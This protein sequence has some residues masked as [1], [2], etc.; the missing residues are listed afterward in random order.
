MIQ[1]IER[2]AFIKQAAQTG[3]VFGIT[4]LTKE[5]LSAAPKPLFQISL[6]QWSLHK[7]LFAKQLDNLD[8]AKTA[9]Q[10]YGINAVEYVNQFFKD[11]AQDKT[12]LGEMLKRT[13][14]LGVEN[15]LIMCDGEGNLGD[16]DAAK[17]QQAVENHYKWVE[18]A[19]FLGCTIIRVNAA[20]RGSYEEQQKLA[21]DGL[22]KLTEFGAQHKI[23]V[24][25]ENHGGLSSNGQWL[26]GVM[27]LVK[28]KNCGTLPDFGNFRL[29][30]TEE[31]DRYKGVA[32]MMPYAKAVSAKTHDFDAE[33]NETH[34]DYRRMV[35][36]V[37]DA[38]YHSFFGIEYEGDKL[39]EPDG[40]RASKKLLER[41]HQELAPK[42]K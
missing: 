38:G 8:F 37:L 25:V 5:T 33:G 24:I 20:S 12:Y 14:D 10:D 11:K 39:S 21:A 9:K 2:R 1:V 4:A 17:R 32:E 35:K 27:K 42:A 36:L 3:A 31:Y 19:K 6:A 29:S 18:A 41:I 26:A 15:R 13:K 40:I 23:A 22:R 16:P 28:H 34:T 7:A 30:P